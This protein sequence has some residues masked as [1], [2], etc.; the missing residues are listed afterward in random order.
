MNEQQETKSTTRTAYLT[1]ANNWGGEVTSLALTRGTDGE[2]TDFKYSRLAVREIGTQQ[3]ITYWTGLGSSK[4]WWSVKFVDSKGARWESKSAQMQG[5]AKG[6]EHQ[7]L[8]FSIDGD[9]E[10]LHI[11]F[12]SGS[13]KETIQLVKK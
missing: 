1:V 6:D 11:F 10:K 13:D 8:L 2:Q 7:V 4:D 5:I 3:P 9:N 12:S